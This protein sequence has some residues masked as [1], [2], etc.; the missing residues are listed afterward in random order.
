MH[1]FRNRRD[2]ALIIV[3]AVVT[4]SSCLVRRRVVAPPGQHEN[5]PLLKANKAELLTRIRN[6]SKA[7]Q[8]FSMKADMAPSVGGIYGGKVTDY[9]TITG[10]ILF[11]RP[12]QIRVI[13]LDP[14]VHST[15]LDMLSMGNDFEVSIP[16]KSLFIDGKN[17][18]PAT[19]ENKLENLR[20]VAFRNALLIE[21]PEAG[22]ATVLEDDTNETKAV[23]IIFCIRSQ[24]DDLHLLRNIYFDRYTLD[25]ARQKTF[26]DAGNVTSDTHYS[27]WKDFGGVRFPATI[28]MQ[29]PVD[30]YELVLTVLDLKFNGAA[31]VTEDKFVLT[32]TPSQ[33]VRVLK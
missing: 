10:Y 32:P 2:F 3:F 24:G 22:L 7:I 23:Y 28:D 25:L 14:V 29:R 12:E 30:G 15:I 19:S 33:Q 6:M 18:A 1:S 13:G 5:R 16:T 27:N 4:L 21:P 8:A 26:D 17:D 11:K 31:E 20:P 9:P